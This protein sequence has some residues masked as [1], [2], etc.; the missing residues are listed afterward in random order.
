MAG[1]VNHW[2]PLHVGDYLGDTAHLSTEQHGAYLLLL[3]AA[4]KRDGRLP[5]DDAQLAAI[6]RLP[7]NRWRQH[8]TVVLGFFRADGD[9]LTNGRVTRELAHAN[10]VSERRREAGARGA[11]SRWQTDSNCHSEPMAN[12][13]A[14][15]WQNDRQPQPQPQKSAVSSETVSGK[16]A[17]KLPEQVKPADVDAIWRATPNKGR[18]RSS[19]SDLSRALKAAVKR[20]HALAEI[21]AA[22][23]RYYAS[24]DATR[25]GG[26]FA[27]GV[28]RLVEADRWKTWADPESGGGVASWGDAQWSIVMDERRAGRP[29]SPEYGPEPGAPGCLVPSQLV[30][31]AVA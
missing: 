21:T 25:D 17:E 16:P 22:H 10:T 13:I 12:A 7:L 28:H 14:E 29:W 9:A 18:E 5:M 6:A 8:R 3:M 1:G 24:D 30:V 15:P 27:K 4:W 26:D 20:G 11:R 31:G 23:S 2:M 19:K